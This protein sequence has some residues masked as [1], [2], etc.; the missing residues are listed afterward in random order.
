[1]KRFQFSRKQFLKL[2]ALIISAYPLKLFYDAGKRVYDSN[3]PLKKQILPLDLPEG[4]SFHGDIIAVRQEMSFQFFS[5]RCPHL[6]CLINRLENEQ[7][8]CPCHGSRFLVDGSVQDGPA[9]K[10]LTLL[11]YAADLNTRQ[12]TVHLPN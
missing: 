10:N 5:A 1:M 12:I 6:G 11:Q 4:V 2:T 9:L 3:G 8:V 7:L